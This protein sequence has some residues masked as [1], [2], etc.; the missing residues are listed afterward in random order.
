MAL[1]QNSTIEDCE[2]QFRDNMR[3]WESY[4]KAVNFL[5]A[6]EYLLQARANSISMGG[7]SVVYGVNDLISLKQDVLPYVKMNN[8]NR[9]RF[10]RAKPVW[11]R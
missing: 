11:R 9:A 5:E 7:R 8:P 1:D 4:T 2:A 3:Y 10:V 6:I